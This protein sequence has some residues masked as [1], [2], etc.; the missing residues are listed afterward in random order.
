MGREQWFVF[1]S[2]A[3]AQEK[4]IALARR[5]AVTI[6]PTQVERLC[7]GELG[8]S[9]V[10]ADLTQ[11]WLSPL[12]VPIAGARAGPGD[13]LFEIIAGRVTVGSISSSCRRN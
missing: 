7:T 2:G 10:S 12:P 4:M 1:V 11:F 3:S 8:N 5:L 6:I 13:E 9:G